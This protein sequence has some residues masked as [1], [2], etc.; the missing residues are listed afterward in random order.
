LEKAIGFG[1]W[2]AARITKRDGAAMEPIALLALALDAAIGW[3]GWLYAHIR[4]PVGGFARVL[5]WME[6]RWNR[7]VLGDPRRRALGVLTVLLLVGGTAVACVLLEA[8]AGWLLGRWAWLGMAVLAWPA[9]AQRSLW[10]HV[11]AVAQA[12]D[13]GDLPLARSRDA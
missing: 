11:R 3:P 10:E 5:A 2:L 1:R 9:L 12:L 7:P 4:H 6:A 13:A 8:A